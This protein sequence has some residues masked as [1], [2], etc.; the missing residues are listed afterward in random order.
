MSA[1]RRNAWLG[2]FG[3][4]LVFTAAGGAD[5]LV[6]FA[7]RAY[8]CLPMLAPVFRADHERQVRALHPVVAGLGGAALL[9]YVVASRWSV[10]IWPRLL[11]LRGDARER[12]RT[13]VAAAVV[14]YSI[15]LVPMRATRDVLRERALTGL[16]EDARRLHLYGVHTLEPDY[17]PIEAFRRASGGQGAVLVARGGLRGSFDDVFLASYLFPQRVFVRAGSGCSPGELPRYR[18]ERPA[19]AWVAWACGDGPFAPFPI[20]PP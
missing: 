13:S 2:V 16:A 19:A 6:A 12:L 11:A 15:L 14:L 1:W 20:A 3:A 5:A 10:A 17:G 18:A 7:S 9:A 4:A 8:Q